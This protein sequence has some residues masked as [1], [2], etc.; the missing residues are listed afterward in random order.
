[1]VGRTGAGKS[2]MILSLMRILE[3]DAGTIRIDGVDIS[4]IGLFD[5]RRNMTIIPQVRR[6]YN[7]LIVTQY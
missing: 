5:L 1:M 3:A 4:Q 2:S 7:P 6:D